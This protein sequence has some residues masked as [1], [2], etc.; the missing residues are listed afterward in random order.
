VSEGD[1][2]PGGGEDNHC[3]KDEL[4]NHAWSLA[5][6]EALAQKAKG[7]QA[8]RSFCLEQLTM[9]VSAA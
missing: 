5:L 3:E 9:T 7:A 8:Q 4:G 6:C 2:R 1:Q